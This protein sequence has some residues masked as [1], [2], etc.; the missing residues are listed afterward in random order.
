LDSER[1][2]LTHL[3]TSVAERLIVLHLSEADISWMRLQLEWWSVYL[4]ANVESKCR[5]PESHCACVHTAVR[6]D[7]LN[8]RRDFLR[9]AS[10]FASGLLMPTSSPQQLFRAGAIP[11][12]RTTA[13]NG[14]AEVLAYCDEFAQVGFHHYEV[15]NTRAGIAQIYVDKVLEFKEQMAMRHLTLVG[16]AQYSR[17]QQSDALAELLEQHMLIG[18]FLAGVGGKYITHMLAPGEILNEGDEAAYKEVDVKIW[19]RNANEIG[20]RLF[21]QW[22]IKFGYHPLRAEVTGGLY[23]RFVDLTDDRFVFLISDIGHLA[24]GGADPIEVCRLYRQRL[25][26]IH[27]KDYSLTPSQ[28]KGTKAGNVPFGQGI[29]N[30][31]GVVAELQRTKFAGWVLGE[32]GGTNLAMRDY[33]VRSLHIML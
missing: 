5:N 7:R 1:L 3:S 16:L 23:K 14:R 12:G 25:I 28:E 29:V 31:A 32:S 26:A 15:N 11:V 8:T 4:F 9:S 20:R 10:C 2:P 17:A 33:M 21:D 13:A 6:V 24:A 19:A 30:M 22:G 27:L 18:R